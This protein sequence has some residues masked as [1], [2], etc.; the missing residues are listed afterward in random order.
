MQFILFI[1]SG[2]AIQT[3][4]Y[5]EVLRSIFIFCIF[6][7]KLV[8]L[9]RRCLW[10][11]CVSAS[12][13]TILNVPSLAWWTSTSEE[14]GSATISSRDCQTGAYANRDIISTPTIVLGGASSTGTAVQARLN[15]TRISSRFVYKKSQAPGSG[16]D[17]AIW[18]HNI[19]SAPAD[20]RFS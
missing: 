14:A 19:P 6:I 8:L 11:R 2:E 20:N 7:N 17:V 3:Q 13:G 9:I 15:P 5:P 18:I 12:G 10:C 16:R 1:V 4:C